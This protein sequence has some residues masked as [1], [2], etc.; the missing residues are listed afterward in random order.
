MGILIGNFSMA[1]EE[2]IPIS[3]L[4]YFSVD[5][6]ETS[7]GTN[8]VTSGTYFIRDDDIVSTTY[9]GID[10]GYRCY[11]YPSS[12]IASGTINLTIHA[13]NSNNEVE[14]HLYSLLYGYNLKFDEIVD[15]GPKTSV[16]I[17]IKASNLALCPNTEVE[18]FYF[19]TMDLWQYELGAIIVPVD[20]VNLGASIYPQN[21]FFFY[22]RTYTITINGVKD[23]GGN[24]MSSYI[25]NFTIENPN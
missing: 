16:D 8:I 9:S 7:S 24:V 2:Y 18:S 21:P 13:T 4:D 10:G 17:S 1:V 22:G 6:I 20:S 14:E 23:F 25:F 3:T 5:V 15:W 19:K 12:L 11:Y